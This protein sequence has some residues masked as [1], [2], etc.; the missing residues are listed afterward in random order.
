MKRQARLANPAVAALAALAVLAAA[1]GGKS[2]SSPAAPTSTPVTTSTTTSATTQKATILVDHTTVALAQ[3]PSEWIERARTTL[4][5]AYGHTSH[6]SQ[7]TTGM[8]GLVAFRGATYAWRSGGTAGALDLRDTPFSG[9]SDLGSPDRTAWAAS[10]RSYLASQPSVNVVMWSWCGQV[11]NATAG[12]IDTYL[13]TMSALE[14]EFPNVRFVYMTGHLDGTG[15]SGNL[16][17][18]NEQIR[19]FC[20][21][22]GKTL[23]D[24]AD[25]ESYDPDGHYYGDRIPD[26]ACDYDSNGDGKR[27][28]NWATDWQSSHTPGV[29]WFQCSSAHSQPVNANM[30]AYGAWW[31]FARLAGWA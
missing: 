30:K 11:S 8:T 1:C 24:F 22:R 28:R 14:Q 18:R 5:I 12:D 25:I 31:L 10:T 2:G 17:M 9:A 16:H 21:S 26:D 4:H 15:L 27:D 29:D 6:G 7:L 19:Q 3:I 23:Y 20:R 13:T